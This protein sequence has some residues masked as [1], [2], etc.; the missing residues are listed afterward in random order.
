MTNLS[1]NKINKLLNEVWNSGSKI[2]NK[3]RYK[4]SIEDHINKINSFKR[5]SYATKYQKKVFGIVDGEPI[6]LNNLVR[7]IEK[8][9]KMRR[10]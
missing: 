5:K 8:V 1:E 4:P 2:P 9:I 10:S 3:I 6:S 7:L